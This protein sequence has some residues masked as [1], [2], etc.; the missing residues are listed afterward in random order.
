LNKTHK[1]ARLFLAI[2]HKQT[3][4]YYGIMTKNKIYQKSVTKKFVELFSKSS[5]KISQKTV[6]R[7][8]F[9]KYF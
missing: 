6:K 3:C 9:V 7:R 2:M 8:F 4:N 5:K 1:S